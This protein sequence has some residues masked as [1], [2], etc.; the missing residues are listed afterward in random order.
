MEK[1]IHKMIEK[2]KQSK[3][4]YKSTYDD[5]KDYLEKS[6]QKVEKFNQ[7]K[8]SHL[9]ETVKLNAE[10]S[11]FIFH[12]HLNN[13]VVPPE[14]EKFIEFENL[15]FDISNSITSSFSIFSS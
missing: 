4:L 13:L 2:N 12:C 3:N 6:A 1:H 14:I 5:I 9:E 8:K 15:S 11:K 7:L 10:I